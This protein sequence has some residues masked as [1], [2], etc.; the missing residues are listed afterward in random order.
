MDFI[1]GQSPST[2]YDN[3]ISHVT[4]GIADSGYND[5]G[6]DWLDVQSNGFGNYTPILH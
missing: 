4:E 5:Y 1:G 2:A 6:P 3:W